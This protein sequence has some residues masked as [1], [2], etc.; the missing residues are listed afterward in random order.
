MNEIVLTNKQTYDHNLYINNKEEID[1]RN[2]EWYGK[3]K[4]ERLKSIIDWRKN[5]PKKCEEAIQ[6]WRDNHPEKI[7]EY[8]KKNSRIHR[9]NLKLETLYHYSYGTM[10]CQCCGE[11]ILEFLSIDHINNNGAEERR[12][13]GNGYALY[14]WLRKNG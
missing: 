2:K 1:K 13:F 6:K 11:S 8:N 10:E 5:N 9:L 3:N 14:L 7:K 12:K 4:N